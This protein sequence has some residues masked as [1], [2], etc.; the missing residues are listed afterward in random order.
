[1]GDTVN[2]AIDGTL[3]KPVEPPRSDRIVAASFP[4]DDDVPWL[5]SDYLHDAPGPEVL[6]CAL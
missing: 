6:T 4:D 2:A 1:V 5:P 3:A